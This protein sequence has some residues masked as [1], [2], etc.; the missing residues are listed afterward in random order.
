MADLSIT[1][2][3]G[4]FDDETSPHLL[5]PDQM[6]RALNVEI[7]H[8][9]LGERRQGMETLA[10]TSS[11][12]D[13]ETGITFLGEHLPTG[14]FT[15]AE[16]WGVG[17][18]PSTS[19]S[20]ARRNAGTW[21]PVSPDDAFLTTA[22]SIYEV[23]ALVFNRKF[24]LAYASAV[25]RLHVWDGTYLRPTG[26]LPP[27]AAPTGANEGAGAFSDVRYYRTREIIRSGAGVA[28]V[29]SEPTSVLTFTPSGGGAGV[30]VTKPTTI[31][32]RSTHWELEAS[33]DGT[34]G[35]FYRIFTTVIGTT[36]VNDE[37][38]TG[39]YPDVGTL[40]DAVGAYLLQPAAKYP[41][42]DD[43][44]ILWAGHFTDDTKKSQFGW[45]VVGS[46]PGV[47]NDERFPIV[48][49]GGTPV[50]N[51]RNVDPTN[52]GDI[53]GL[54]NATNGVGVIFKWNR[55]YRYNRT[56]DFTN[57]YEVNNLSPEIG[58]I[59][60]SVV[61]GADELGRACTYFVDPQTGPWRYGQF[62]LQRI[63]GLR[64]TWRRANT[65]ATTVICRG[66]YYPDKQQVIWVFA[67]DTN[68]APTLGIKLQ[69][70]EVQSEG[71]IARRGWTLFDGDIAK[72]YALCAFHE[73]VTGDPTSLSKS[74]RARP[75]GGYVSPN[76][77]QRWD[78]G[79]TDNGTAFV[80]WIRTKPFFLAGLLQ[81]WGALMASLLAASNNTFSLVVNFLVDS[82]RD[83]S[84]LPVTVNLLPETSEP[85]V[86]KDL[87]AL[88]ASEARSL[89]IEFKD[90]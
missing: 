71:G 9:A 56:L 42:I 86:V 55:T 64:T 69:V 44:R 61:N 68:N 6:T 4:G 43:D 14:V 65:F 32:P 36:T 87:D 51:F 26:L 12:L 83:V 33:Q 78:T 37:T 85:I 84:N 48:D 81:K 72:A 50:V 40:S 88:V 41:A 57:A 21:I 27:A 80:A 63:R 19:V 29:R 60:G 39:T 70:T 47:G 35:N 16:M 45:S 15:N 11:S 62:G 75:F 28:L 17:A 59:P 77:V 46:D 58:A 66:V 5:E 13:D 2:L 22:P 25:D 34:T 52:G 3:R 76:F 8:A 38:P 18:T 31:N 82:G 7:F 20:V 74:L 73:V 67:A 10:M 24:F 54:S 30:I 23:M 89:T 49:T 79:T 90:P 1:S 53:T